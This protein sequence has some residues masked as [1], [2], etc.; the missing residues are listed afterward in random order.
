VSAMSGRDATEQL[1]G[2]GALVEAVLHCP[3][4]GLAGTTLA[5]PAALEDRACHSCGAPVVVSVLTRSPR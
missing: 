4:C 5:R 1:L 2:T 3:A